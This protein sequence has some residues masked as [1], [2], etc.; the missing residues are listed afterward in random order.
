MNDEAKC[1]NCHGPATRLL[2]RAELGKRQDRRLV[3]DDADCQ[4]EGTW[5]SYARDADGLARDLRAKEKS[6]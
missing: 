1:S 2:V 3:C 5:E 6:R 4:P